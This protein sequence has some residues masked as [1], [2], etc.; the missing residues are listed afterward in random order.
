MLT[1]PQVELAQRDL[2]NPSVRRSL[3]CPFLPSSLAR[4]RHTDD[5]P[6]QLTLSN[7]A[8]SLAAPANCSSRR[9]AES[10]KSSSSRPRRRRLRDTVLSSESL[11][12]HRAPPLPPHRPHPQAQ[13]QPPSESASTRNSSDSSRPSSGSSSR[14]RRARK[15][16]WLA[17]TRRSCSCGHTSVCLSRNSTESSS[18][19]LYVLLLS[20]PQMAH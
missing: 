13:E 2:Y 10:R 20:K 5:R 8:G 12:P 17:R 7:M 15:C 3:R 14:T 6:R 18:A 19:I 11:L 1:T 16:G 4:Q 9:E